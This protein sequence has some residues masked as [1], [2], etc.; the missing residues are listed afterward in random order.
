MLSQAHYDEVKIKGDAD[1]EADAH[2][3]RSASGGPEFYA[4]LKQMKKL[5]SILGDNRRC[6]SYRRS[7]D[8]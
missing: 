4:L 2:P 1:A 7:E 6:C 3:Q 5:Q 8:V